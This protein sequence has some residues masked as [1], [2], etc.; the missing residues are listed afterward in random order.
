[1]N[2][3]V[4]LIILS[5]HPTQNQIFH[6]IY[7]LAFCISHHNFMNFIHLALRLSRCPQYKL[8]VDQNVFRDMKC[9]KK[10]VVIGK[11]RLI[12]FAIPG[13]PSVNIPLGAV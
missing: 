9:A 7:N 13:S 11:T 8:E 1:M 2:P 6:T 3:F 10:V 12:A 4:L 5:A